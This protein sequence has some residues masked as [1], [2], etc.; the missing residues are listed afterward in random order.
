MN[1]CCFRGRFFNV[2]C[3]CSASAAARRAIVLSAVS[4]DHLIDKTG[5]EGTAVLFRGGQI[6]TIS[7][8]MIRL[9][10]N[11]PD[12]EKNDRE[13]PAYRQQGI[14]KQQHSKEGQR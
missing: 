14:V 3:Y 13:M 6:M 8:G 9:R 4:T 11:C 2:C 1:G 7:C 12:T 10:H 5:Q